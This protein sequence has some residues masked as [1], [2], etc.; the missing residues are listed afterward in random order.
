M[1]KGSARMSQRSS[2]WRAP[3]RVLAAVLTVAA[4][5]G[6]SAA[7]AIGAP[8]PRV[9]VRIE[10]QNSTVFQGP[11]TVGTYGILDTG[12]VAHDAGGTALAAVESA[13]RIG[14]FAYQ[15]DDMS[16][17]LYLSSINGELPVYTDP[18]PGWLYRV[19]GVSLP[20]GAADAVLKDGDSVLWYY[21]AWDASPTVA[22]APRVVTA[23]A[24]ARIVAQQLDPDGV[25]SPLEGATVR[26]GS[27]AFTSGADGSVTVPM[28]EVGAYGV[29]VEK[30]GFIRSAVSLMD[31]RYTTAF[32][33][34]SASKSRVRPRATVTLRG[35]LASDGSDAAG[36][37]VRLQYKKKGSR[38]W[39]ASTRA[40]TN[41]SGAF[42]FKVK[43]RRSTYYR[44]VY[45]GD[46]THLS[47]TSTAK[48]VTVR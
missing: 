5:A 41:A 1:S 39:V 3:A 47:A 36:R 32:S 13:A 43:P 48:L 26:V 35:A 27:R 31:V 11:V 24:S 42:S 22:V 14:S 34:F 33:R 44:V 20:V 29:R 4:L 16:F 38:T 19:N 46:A 37:P 23:G 10:G 30:P 2:L 28:S 18:Y 17:G 7:T 25:A 8:A 21:G 15:V 45:A 9:S 12:G 6:L 40:T